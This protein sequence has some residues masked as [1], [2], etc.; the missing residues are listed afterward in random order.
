VYRSGMIDLDR[1]RITPGT[2][3][4]LAERPSKDTQGMARADAK[5]AT[6]ANVEALQGLQERLYAEGRQSLL[7]VLQAMDTAGKDTTIGKVIGPL[8]PLGVR[9][10]SF[11]A[12]SRH[13]LSHDFLW[14]VHRRTPGAGF[15]GVFNR[16]HYE[17]VLIVR[18]R[19]LAPPEVVERRYEHINAIE[20]LLH[21]EG[22]RIVKVMLHISKEYQLERLKRRLKR[23]DRHWK[24]E[25]GDLRERE[26]W[27]E[28]QAA[29]DLALTRCSTEYAPWHV[30]PA[31]RRWFRN[32][33]VS[34]LLRKTLEE[35]D[36]QYPAPSFDPADYPPDSLV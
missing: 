6:R 8:N 32:L 15:I 35:M 24:F 31:E 4:R 3:A 36:P 16:S 23:P 9:V 12:P 10:W 29:Y 2:A 30:V 5:A 20:R 13:E 11:K 14:R 28:Y 19:G 18:V 25:P 33:V 34:S 7:F 22:T 17:D 26:R 27:D 21:D 1:Y